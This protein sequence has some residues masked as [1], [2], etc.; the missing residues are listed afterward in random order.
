MSC[1]ENIIDREEMPRKAKCQVIGT[2]DTL[3]GMLQRNIC[4][5]SSNH[6]LYAPAKYQGVHC[7]RGWEKGYGGDVIIIMLITC[8]DL[9]YRVEINLRQI[10][11]TDI[12]SKWITSQKF[13][14]CKSFFQDARFNVATQASRDLTWFSKHYRMNKKTIWGEIL[15][16]S[17]ENAS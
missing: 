7:L 11:H 15:L 16:S 5:L 8:D 13:W 4:V 17:E 10:V 6:P 12:S 1:L 2:P 9:K 3:W 14:N